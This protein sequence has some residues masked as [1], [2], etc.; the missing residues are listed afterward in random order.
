MSNLLQS[1][2][3]KP[4]VA[5]GKQLAQ[6]NELRLGSEIMKQQREQSMDVEC[7]LNEAYSYGS[8][9]PSEHMLRHYSD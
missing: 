2:A 3:D 4:R 9:H 1:T 5:S 6:D 8:V 7:R